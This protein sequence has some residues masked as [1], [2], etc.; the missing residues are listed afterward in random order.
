MQNSGI[1]FLD[2]QGVGKKYS[3]QEGLGILEHLKKAN[4]AQVIVA[5]SGHSFDLSKNRFWQLADDSLCK[6]VQATKCKELIDDIIKTRLNP[7]HY[8]SCVYQLLL[9]QGYSARNIKKL[10]D[11]VYSAIEKKDQR[12][13]HALINSCIDKTEIAA[14]VGAVALKICALIP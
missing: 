9:N 11:K 10:E 13:I 5:F 12:D 8:W 6:P 1:I 3:D 4:P 7:K 2:I 14:K